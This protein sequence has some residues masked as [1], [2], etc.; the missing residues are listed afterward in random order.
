MAY[1]NYFP[2]TYQPVFNPYMQQMQQAQMQ[3]LQ[4]MQQP[5]Q[6]PTQSGE[7]V[8]VQMEEEARN[9]PVAPGNSVTFKNVNEPYF[10]TKTMG[11]SQL[12]KPEFKRY[13][14]LED[15]T[16]QAMPKNAQNADDS[17]QGIDLSMYALKSDLAALQAEFD[18]LKGEICKNPAKTP[19][20]DAKKKGDSN[21]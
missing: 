12:D 2:A 5:Q 16:V 19:K 11:F 20:I 4:Q 10:Y 6:K 14:V 13:R 8:F 9:Y 1:N 21:E 7:L 17:Q 18:S 3:Q 15:E